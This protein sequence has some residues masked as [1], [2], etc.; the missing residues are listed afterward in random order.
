MA[1]MSNYAN[2]R[3]LVTGGLGSIDS[4]FARALIAQGAEVTLVQQLALPEDE[5]A[6]IYHLVIVA[7]ERR[8]E[9]Q[10]HMQ[11][12]QVQSLIR[13]PLPIHM[14]Q[15]CLDIA[16]DPQGLAKNSFQGA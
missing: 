4:K 16:R 15:P 12:Y 8:D 13:Y 1:E 2:K 7:C 11:L 9:L 6:H 10:V 5:P 14:Q 3:S